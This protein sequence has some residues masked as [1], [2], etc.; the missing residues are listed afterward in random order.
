MDYSFRLDYEMDIRLWIICSDQGQMDQYTD[1]LVWIIRFDYCNGLQD[2]Y[3]IMD[4]S[5]RLM[6]NEMD[7][8]FAHVSGL[9]DISS[10][11]LK[12]FLH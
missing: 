2:G 11:S 7:I 1:I 4:Y 6:D 12:A 3:S 10:M 9:R 8:R 5:L